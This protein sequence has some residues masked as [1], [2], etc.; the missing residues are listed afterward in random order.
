MTSTCPCP[1][2][3]PPLPAATP[4]SRSHR[5]HLLAVTSKSWSWS[6]TTPPRKQILDLAMVSAS[7][8]AKEILD[9]M[10]NGVG[11]VAAANWCD[12]LHPFVR[13][14]VINRSPIMHNRWEWVINRKGKGCPF[15][16]PFFWFSFVFCSKYSDFVTDYLSLYRPVPIFRPPFASTHNLNFDTF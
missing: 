12:L 3:S 10:S 15:F 13:I 1:S 11:C 6:W 4:L 14:R 7:D 9:I 5:C 8:G 2:S 16:P